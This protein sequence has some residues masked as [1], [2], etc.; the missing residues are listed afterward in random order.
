MY[1]NTRKELPYTVELDW[2]TGNIFLNIPSIDSK[3]VIDKKDFD[4]IKSTISMSNNRNLLRTIKQ[5]DIFYVANETVKYKILDVTSGSFG[6]FNTDIEATENVFEYIQKDEDPRMVYLCI[7][8][9][10]K[11]THVFLC[12]NDTDELIYG[13]HIVAA[14]LIDG[15]AEKIIAKSL[16]E[17]NTLDDDGNFIYRRC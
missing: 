17:I 15:E 16:S 7:N 4:S 5:G 13:M 11:E 10:N 12:D 1:E 6:M 9:S 14:I 8:H 3:L 2:Q